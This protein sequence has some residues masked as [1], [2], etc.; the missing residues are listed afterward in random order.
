MT[1]QL[2]G[3][4]YGSNYAVVR[5]VRMQTLMI[6]YVYKI[7]SHS[8]VS[9]FFIRCGSHPQRMPKRTSWSE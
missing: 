7:F 9:L 4:K 3:R 5:C 1:M 6:A 8:A 2:N